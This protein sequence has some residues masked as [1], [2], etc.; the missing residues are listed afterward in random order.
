MSE[1]NSQWV[2][3]VLNFECYF[4]NRQKIKQDSTYLFYVLSKNQ[5][6]NVVCQHG[7]A[8]KQHLGFDF[9]KVH[10]KDKLNLV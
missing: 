8:S 5:N 10:K 1:S 3:D 2:V 6:L 7:H 4:V 9:L